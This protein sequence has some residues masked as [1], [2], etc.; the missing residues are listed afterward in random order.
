MVV[1]LWNVLWLLLV[2]AACVLGMHTAL[3]TYRHP[4]DV[5]TSLFY[6]EPQRARRTAMIVLFG[7][8]A[9]WLVIALSTFGFI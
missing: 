2:S 6:L 3:E 7:L 4:R 8:P 5:R 9:I 1:N